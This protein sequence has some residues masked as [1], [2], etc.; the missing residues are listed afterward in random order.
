M[1]VCIS[2]PSYDCKF[3]AKVDYLLKKQFPKKGIYVTYCKSIKY[4]YFYFLTYSQSE[5]VWFLKIVFI[6]IFNKKNKMNKK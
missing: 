3:R 2:A 6:P 4:N 1:F 5:K